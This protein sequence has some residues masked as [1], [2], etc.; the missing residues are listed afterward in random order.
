LK[1][2]SDDW[3]NSFKI[4]GKRLN[5]DLIHLYDIYI[6]VVFFILGLC[7]GYL[8]GYMRGKQKVK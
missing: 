3:K 7:F 6:G 5:M 8:I 1:S 2:G 4:K